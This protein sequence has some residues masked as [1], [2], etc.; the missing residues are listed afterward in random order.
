MVDTLVCLDWPLSKPG[1][2]L[3]S[4]VNNRYKID[5][6]HK[7]HQTLTLTKLNAKNIS[8]LIN[9]ILTKI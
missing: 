6:A 1:L 2:K 8:F 4:L 5:S 7:H 3:F 9:V